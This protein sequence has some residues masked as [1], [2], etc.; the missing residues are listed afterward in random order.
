MA[1]SS[2]HPA[3]SSTPLVPPSQFLPPIPRSLSG[4]Q[5][6]TF[7]DHVAL[8][9]KIFLPR[10][11]ALHPCLLRQLHAEPLRFSAVLGSG[12]EEAPDSGYSSAEEQDQQPATTDEDLF[13]ALRNDTFEKEWSQSWLLRL[14]KRGESWLE[15]CEEDSP[16][17]VKRENVVEAAS[18]GLPSLLHSSSLI[19]SHPNEC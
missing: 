12:K 4:F 6:S 7:S 8:L 5:P 11:R 3:A 2:A 16:E 17:W 19:L 1:S 13:D 14:V 10:E 9:H 18:G 15:E